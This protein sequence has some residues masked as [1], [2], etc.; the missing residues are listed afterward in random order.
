MQITRRNAQ[1]GAG[2]AV[3]VAGVQERGHYYVLQTATERLVVDPRKK[4]EPGD[5]VVVWAKKRGPVF[6]RRLA[7]CAP[8]DT[9]HFRTLDTGE[10]FEL[11]CSK[12]S[13][14]HAVDLERLAVEA[15]S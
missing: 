10:V 15:R 6:A 3:V 9:F 12:V 1:V 5:L 11:P 4:G 8:Y 13:M 2:A 7:R 14:I